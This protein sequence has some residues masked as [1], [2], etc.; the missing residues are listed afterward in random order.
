MLAG[1][2]LKALCRG[3]HVML[4]V[5]AQRLDR[6]VDHGRIRGHLGVL[7]D[8]F[9]GECVGDRGR[10]GSGAQ[11]REVTAMKA[12]TADIGTTPAKVS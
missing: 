3:D 1:A 11:P 10:R 6:S 9:T 12:P 4:G 7:G 5:C 8:D 2:F